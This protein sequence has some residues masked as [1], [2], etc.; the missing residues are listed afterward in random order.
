MWALFSIAPLPYLY[1]MRKSLLIFCC[2]LF[3]STL[4]AQTTK[5]KIETTVGD[6][7]V[8]LYDDVPKHRA[9]FIKLANNHQLDSTLFHR[10][11]K[12]FM[13]Q[14]G[15]PD[16]KKAGPDDT[17][18]NGDLGYLVD[19]ELMP[20]IHFHKKGVIA[21]ARDDIPSKASSACQF[22]IVQGKVFTEA[23]LDSAEIKRKIVIPAA[24]RKVYTTIGGTPHLDG[25]YT[26][27]GEVIQG[28]A[29]VDQI[30]GVKTNALDRPIVNVRILK[31]SVVKNRWRLFRKRNK[32]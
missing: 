10:V 3:C 25:N 11:I 2:I 30:A 5:V 12:G 17:L 26:V 7:I 28:L 29:I 9:N 20:D 32:K 24:R 4:K 16:S 1:F 22:Y 18:G 8:V 23:G 21:A 13:I 31:V 6:I 27:F 19:A 14:G 15:D